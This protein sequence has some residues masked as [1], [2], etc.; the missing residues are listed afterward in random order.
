MEKE[1]PSA[2]LFLKPWLHKQPSTKKE[3]SPRRRSGSMRSWNSQRREPN[4]SAPHR[5]EWP[6]HLGF[7][8]QAAKESSREEHPQMASQLHW[9]I[10]FSCDVMAD[11]L[12]LAPRGTGME[13]QQF[14][15]TPK[16]F[17]HLL[18]TNCN[19]LSCKLVHWAQS[20]LCLLMLF[21]V[22]AKSGCPRDFSDVFQ[23]F[24]QGP[25]APSAQ[26]VALSQE[27]PHSALPSTKSLG[28][29]HLWSAP[30]EKGLLPIWFTG[31]YEQTLSLISH[32]GCPRSA[33]QTEAL[34]E[35]KKTKHPL[36]YLWDQHLV[37]CLPTHYHIPPWGNSK[38]GTR[39][40]GLQRQ[41]PIYTQVI[42]VKQQLLFSASLSL[43]QDGSLKALI[44]NQ[45]INLGSD[46]HGSPVCYIHL[47][48]QRL[49]HCSV[50]HL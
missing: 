10:C 39:S 44:I 1:R 29:F 17:L 6:C 15:S 7:S 14:P 32:S 47:P 24:L 43:L 2:P 36:I 13:R 4:L 3:R 35:I 45:Q 26:D 16:A 33:T 46:I 19:T 41:L 38:K 31:C 27:L 49:S 5:D 23:R 8:G 11:Q 12:Q 9:L 22:S 40:I 50:Y 30:L 42:G 48:S 20:F 21:Q 18:H 34:Q 25:K 28:S 37:P